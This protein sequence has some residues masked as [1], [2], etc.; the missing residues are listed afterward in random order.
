MKRVAI[1]S[2]V[3]IYIFE[4]DPKFFQDSFSLLSTVEKGSV[5]GITSIISII[6]SLSSPK[7]DQ[8]A[9]AKAEIAQFFDET[10]HLRVFP[11]DRREGEVAAMLRRQYFS[12][13]TPDAVQLATAL[14]HQADVFVTN[15]AQLL[16]LKHPPLP[17][18][19]LNKFSK[20]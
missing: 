2:M 3:F 1:D 7:L 18:Q 10:A 13:Y 5:E 12:L 9:E 8:A 15:D 11:V 14:V 19:S 4:K 20:R 6:E 17:I 16:R